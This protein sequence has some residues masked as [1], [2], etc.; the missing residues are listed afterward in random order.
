MEIKAK[1]WYGSAS[2]PA[3]RKA[4]GKKYLVWKSREGQFLNIFENTG[5]NRVFMFRDAELTESEQVKM[6]G[7]A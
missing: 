7:R 4:L 1:I 6:E 2:I 3:L 5:P